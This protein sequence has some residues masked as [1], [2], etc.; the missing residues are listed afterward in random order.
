ML[1]MML[2]EECTR[3]TRLQNFGTA[4]LQETSLVHEA[5]GPVHG[6]HDHS[7][8]SCSSLNSWQVLSNKSMGAHLVESAVLASWKVF[9]LRIDQAGWRSGGH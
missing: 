6:I 9:I 2:R 3:R 7:V 5:S 1:A 8:S 4:A